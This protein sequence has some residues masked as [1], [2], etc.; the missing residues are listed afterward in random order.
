MRRKFLTVSLLLWL[1]FMLAL[2]FT[3]RSP[4]AGPVVA[5][6]LRQAAADPSDTAKGAIYFNTTSNLPEA[7]NGTSWLNAPLIAGNL[8][9]AS[10]K[11]G[12]FSNTLTLAG[13]DGANLNVS[14]GGTLGS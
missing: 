8:A 12:T 2:C 5:S 14:A 3:P 1:S 10:G 11:T 9:I 7:Y 13:T 4:A 6:R